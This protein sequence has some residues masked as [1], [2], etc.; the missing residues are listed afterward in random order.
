MKLAISGKGGVGKT[1]IAG[2]LARLYADEGYKVLAVDADPDANLASAIGISSQEASKITP[3]SQLKKLVKERTGANPGDMG[4][5]FTLNP[6]V[7]DIPDKYSISYD[8]IKLLIMGSVESGG[9]GCVCPESALLRSLLKNL[10]LQ[11]D[12]VVIMDMEAG[13]EHLGRSTAEA[14]DALVIVVEPGQRSIQTAKTIKKL[15]SDIGIKK[16]FLVMN[17]VKDKVEVEILIRQLD[18]FAFLGHLKENKK[19]RQSDLEGMSAYDSDQAFVKEIKE[20]KKKL[21]K[22]LNV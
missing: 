19:I 20:I 16:I 11:R 9:A 7:D 4:S 10:L 17:K 22:V 15:A 18:D 3:I 6:K 21:E 8:G 12:E 1:T 2:A 5:F 14:V 13:I